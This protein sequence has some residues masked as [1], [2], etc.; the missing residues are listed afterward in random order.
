MCWSTGRAPMAQPPGSDTRASPQRATSGPST[1]IDARMVLTS[2]Y[3]AT[4][5]VISAAS[6]VTVSPSRRVCTP[7]LPSRRSRVSMSFSRGTLVRTS[8]S[9]VSSA[10]HRIGKAA[11]L[12][13]EMPISPRR[14]ALFSILSLSIADS[15]SQRGSHDSPAGRRVGLQS[16]RVDLSA[17]D[18]VSERPLHHAMLVRQGN[19]FEHRA[20]HDCAEMHAVV[21][22][23]VD[24]LTVQPFCDQPFDF[25]CLEH[26]QQ[27]LG[28]TQLRSL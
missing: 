8:G 19:A 22:L 9:R 17:V 3:G 26:L 25:G 11:F 6:S 12:A 20:H 2:S 21:P 27:F 16:K 10:A 5:S 4:G 24:E 28:C 23:H 7:M 14:R 13:P 18:A 1:R 15:V